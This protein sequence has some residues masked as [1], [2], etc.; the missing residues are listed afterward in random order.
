M[1]MDDILGDV[2]LPT[3]HDSILQTVL[4]H[5]KSCNLRLNFEKVRV[6]KQQVQNVGHIISAEGLKPDPKKV[7]AMKDMS[8]K[9]LPMLA[10]VKMP[11]QELTRKHV[12]FIGTRV[13]IT[14]NLLLGILLSNMHQAENSLSSF[15]RLLRKT[16][17]FVFTQFLLLVLKRLSFINF[18]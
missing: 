10:E 2:M 6:R 3:N 18:L 5:A 8:P 9:F 17:A 12:H 1:H 13:Q 14:I 15:S 4:H 11:L 7:R 16:T